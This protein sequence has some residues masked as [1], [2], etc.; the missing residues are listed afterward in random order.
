MP[1]LKPGTQ[2]IC[3]ECGKVIAKPEAGWLEW[4]FLDGREFGF[5][6]VH[7]LTA[8]PRSEHIPA[9]N[10]WTGEGCYGVIPSGQERS[11]H[12]ETMLGIGG[13]LAMLDMQQRSKID[14][15]EWTELFKRLFL[16][17]YEEGRAW[18]SNDGRSAY[19]F[20]FGGEC[21]PQLV[22]SPDGLHLIEV[23]RKELA[24]AAKH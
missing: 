24:E 16:P 9:T 20:T 21:D 8:S 17:Y 7:H 19:D 2:W 10:Q 15:A 1:N 6:I 13:M 5:R 18:P 4:R 22:I 14:L 23:A 11:S 3:D 12:L